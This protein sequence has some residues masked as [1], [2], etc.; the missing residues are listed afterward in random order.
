MKFSSEYSTRRQVVLMLLTVLADL[1]CASK[2]ET[3]GYIKN[4]HFFDVQAEDWPPYPKA[5]THEPRWHTLIA[6]ARKTGVESGLLMDGER[7]AWAISRDGVHELARAQGQYR[8]AHLAAGNCYMWTP[9]FKKLMQPAY[10]P[11]ATDAKRP[12]NVYRDALEH[13]F[14]E[15]VF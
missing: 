6:W 5:Q 14:A 7:D 13:L 2:Q 4:R 3:I 15:Y 12:V 11:S 9:T 8:S 10:L 1:R